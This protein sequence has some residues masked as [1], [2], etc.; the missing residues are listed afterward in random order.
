[1]E[2]SYEELASRVPSMPARRR[3]A[4]Q[5]AVRPP[6]EEFV[7]F[8]VISDQDE[9]W[10]EQPEVDLVAIEAPPPA[11]RSALLVPLLLVAIGAVVAAVVTG[12][13]L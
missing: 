11:E 4:R 5:W 12:V 2:V 13:L 1:M 10:Y 6:D 3:T 9:L 7:E 8:R